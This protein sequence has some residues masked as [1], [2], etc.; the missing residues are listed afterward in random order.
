MTSMIENTSQ[1]APSKVHR[2]HKP[3]L[4]SRRDGQ[5]SSL[6]EWE[7]CLAGREEAAKSFGVEAHKLRG[8]AMME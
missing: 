2:R 8:G 3:K 1:G 6:R 4:S 5:A 7:Y